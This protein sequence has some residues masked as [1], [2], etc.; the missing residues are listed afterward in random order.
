MRKYYY[1][2]GQ[3]KK[4]PFSLDDLK[5]EDLSKD[6]LIWYSGLKDW[7]P[8]SQIEEFVEI[9][10][11]TPPPLNKPDESSKYSDH[12]V[13]NKSDLLTFCKENI[14]SKFFFSLFN[15]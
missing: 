7:V 2:Y 4:G 15:L 12:T 14:P 9:L 3:D 6:T 11:V 8:A 13:Q 10:K 1:L 5:L